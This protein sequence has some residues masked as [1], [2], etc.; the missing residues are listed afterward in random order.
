MCKRL[1]R[2][3]QAL[4]LWGAENKK[5]EHCSTRTMK[6]REPSVEA[7][8]ID[9]LSNPICVCALESVKCFYLQHAFTAMSNVA[10]VLVS[11]PK[12]SLTNSTQIV[13]SMKILAVCRG[14]GFVVWASSWKSLLQ[15]RI[16]PHIIC[17]ASVPQETD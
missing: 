17:N 5:Q 12:S 8:I 16:S 6:T 13:R 15:N 4:F 2:L 9:Y 3:G 14:N 10:T 1:L 11:V 7:V